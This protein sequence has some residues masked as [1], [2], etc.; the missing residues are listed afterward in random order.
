M[1]S[2][3]CTV[4]DRGGTIDWGIRLFDAVDAASIGS[5]IISNNTAVGNRRRTVL[6]IDP[7]TICSVAVLQGKPIE[8]RIRSFA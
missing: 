6:D 7:A 3:N 8:D 1:V 2:G 5:G 4:F